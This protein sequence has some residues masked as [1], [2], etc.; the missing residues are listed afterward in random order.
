MENTESG[1]QKR[2][3]E[4]VKIASS[5]NFSDISE[6]GVFIKTGNPRRL[7][8]VLSLEIKLE[9]F[10]ESLR[11]MAKVIRVIH[12]AGATPH[13]PAGMAMQFV[14]PTEEIRQKVRDFI[15]KLKQENSV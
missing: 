6:G 8:S 2:Q 10:P 15:V 5:K 9:G 11:V 7:G 14:N 4:R 3:H 1:R 13:Q 12:P